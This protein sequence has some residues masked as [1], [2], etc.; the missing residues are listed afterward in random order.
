LVLE[1][2]QINQIHLAIKFWFLQQG[3]GVSDFY[4]VLPVTGIC[5]I[6]NKYN[7]F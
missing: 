5:I 7:R 6:S 3:Q 1:V 2:Q 4:K